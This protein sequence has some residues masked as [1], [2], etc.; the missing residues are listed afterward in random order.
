LTTQNDGGQQSII[1]IV[2]INIPKDYR[3]PQKKFKLTQCNDKNAEV[4]LSLNIVSLE[5]IANGSEKASSSHIKDSETSMKSILEMK[6]FEKEII[7]P[8]NLFKNESSSS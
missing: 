7:S 5:E 4:E 1:A 8:P 2:L 6:G 3:I